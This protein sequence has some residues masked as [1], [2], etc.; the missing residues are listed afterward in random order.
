MKYNN[1]GEKIVCDLINMII[2]LHVNI[3]YLFW[4]TKSIF[5][6]FYEYIDILYDKSK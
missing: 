5:K 1:N 4:L 6:I 2:F 3:S